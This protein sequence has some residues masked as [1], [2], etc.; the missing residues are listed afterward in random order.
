M[1]ITLILLLIAGM[2]GSNDVT[3]Y[4]IRRFRLYSRPEAAKEE[5]THLFRGLVFAVGLA[6]LLYGRPLGAWYWVVFGLFA[7]DAINNVLDVMFETAS[8]APEGVPR[9]EL[10]IHYFGTLLMGATWT[11]F[12]LAGWEGRLEATALAPHVTVLPDWVFWLGY[13]SLA[14]SVVLLL[15]EGGLFARAIL[16]R[17]A[18]HEEVHV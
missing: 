2:V 17:R 4:H 7:F 11:A 13:F 3:H 14:T 6:I 1:D 10:V 15:V 18:A 16:A 8:R 9:G 5:I 12:T